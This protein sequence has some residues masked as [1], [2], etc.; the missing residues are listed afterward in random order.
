MTAKRR[1]KMPSSGQRPA[2]TVA[3]MPF[4][5]FA[6]RISVLRYRRYR[7]RVR[8][9]SLEAQETF[10]Y[11]QQ[12]G[13]YLAYLYLRRS[14]V[15]G[16]AAHAGPDWRSKEAGPESGPCHSDLFWKSNVAN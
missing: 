5:L 2:M 13:R 8:V 9:E 3:M 11:A 10:T 1:G 16:Q 7:S 6:V 14:C 4:G 12:P 15:S